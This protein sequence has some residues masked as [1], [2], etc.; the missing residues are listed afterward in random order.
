MRSL[1]SPL[2]TT[3]R[4]AVT[5][6][7]SLLQVE[8]L[9]QRQV[10]T[11]FTGPGHIV[12]ASA[13]LLPTHDAPANHALLGPSVVAQTQVAVH[14]PTQGHDAI[15]RHVTRTRSHHVPHH[16]PYHLP[17]RLPHHL[18]YHLP[19]R[20]PH[21]VL[22]H[23]PHQVTHV[24]AQTNTTTR[25]GTFIVHDFGAAISL[26]DPTAPRNTH[27]AGIGSG[28]IAATAIAD[29]YQ[30]LGG[31]L[32]I[33]GSPTTPLR[34]VPDGIG[35]FENYQNGVI[36]WAPFSGA[37][38]IRDPIVAK[39]QSLGGTAFGYP[40]TDTTVT[41][42]G[43]VV[44]NHFQQADLAGNSIF[45]AGTALAA[46]DWTEEYGTHAVSGPIATK[47]AG[48]GWEGAGIAITDAT[49][50]NQ[51]LFSGPSYS[52]AYNR[53]A[54]HGSTSFKPNFAIDATWA[55]ASTPA[56][57]SVAYTPSYNDIKQG[58]SNTCWI[59]AS[60]V[61][62]EANGVTELASL[63]QYQG[64]NMYQV[65]LHNW[66]DVAGRPSGGTHEDDVSVYFDGTTTAADPGWNPA[67]PSSS[68]TIIL[69][70]A[71]I[72]AVQEWDPSESITNPH[73]GGAG[74]ALGILTGNPTQDF[75]P[76]DSNIAQEVS[77]AL[78]QGKNV[79][80]NTNPTTTTNLVAYHDYAILSANSRYVTLYNPWGNNN[81]AGQSIPATSDPIII[82]PWSIIAQDGSVIT[83]N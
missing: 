23:L 39:W 59:L 34:S 10:P 47:F 75:S 52:A 65:S 80:L 77:A 50:I 41:G 29:K 57:V 17:H 53:F 22:H 49:H 35:M 40:I 69:Q 28:G 20:V 54:Y 30:S 5:R 62:V 64:G 26:F 66:N 68:W 36:Y 76:Q 81:Q 56:T 79:V 61:A 3:S 11:T 16:P 19:H 9:E 27:P 70:R 63:I 55:N 6:R 38:F 4:P 46:I 58:N 51:N 74:D 13:H 82:V 83:A 78:G 48:M 71:V 8:S 73:G 25:D 67:D 43:R 15:D 33:L 44:F 42:D 2:F 12:A 37:H 32:G 31:P 45:D 60:I 18:P 14:V 72:E 21:H 1:F 7:R 24:P